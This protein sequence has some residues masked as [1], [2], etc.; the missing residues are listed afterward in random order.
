[1]RLDPL[2]LQLQVMLGQLVEA[3][4]GESDVVQAHFAAGPRRLALGRLLLGQR[5]GIDKG[6]PVVLVI[7]ADE[8]DVLVL[9]QHLGS[10]SGAI[11]IDHLLPPIGLQHEMRQLF[12]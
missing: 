10:E 1:M 4:K 3:A 8:G 11:P 2:L 7:I 9:E 5:P 12:R 6:D